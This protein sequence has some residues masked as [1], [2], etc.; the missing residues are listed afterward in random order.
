MPNDPYVVSRTEPT[1]GTYDAPAMRISF[2]PGQAD[3]IPRGRSV[4]H[5]SDRFPSEP[6]TEIAGRIDFTNGYRKYP[7]CRQV[8]QSGST[9][10]FRDSKGAVRDINEESFI[11]L[12]QELLS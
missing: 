7:I 12:L 9:W 3:L 11:Q 10:R 8:G 4:S 5:L 2:G 6:M 1:L